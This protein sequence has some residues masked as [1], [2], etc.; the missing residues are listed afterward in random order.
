MILYESTETTVGN[1]NL[2][3]VLLN[4]LSYSIHICDS[5]Y[6]THDEVQVQLKVYIFAFRHLLE[7]L[8]DYNAF[9]LKLLQLLLLSPYFQ[10][11]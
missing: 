3:N 6:V 2:K 5:H 8:N 11:R 7:P 1:S 9:I 10:T 4:N